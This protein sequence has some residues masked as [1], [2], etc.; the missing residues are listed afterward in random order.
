MLQYYLP[1]NAIELTHEAL[2][3]QPNE[4]LAA[5]NACLRDK[6]TR[7]ATEWFAPGG[8]SWVFRQQGLL[9]RDSFNLP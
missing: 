7:G 6:K 4:E 2:V 8:G 1:A 9:P 5:W 3:T